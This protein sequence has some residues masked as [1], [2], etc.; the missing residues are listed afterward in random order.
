MH[1]ILVICEEAG[2]R[3]ACRRELSGE[4]YDVHWVS[5][6][7]SALKYIE[8]HKVDLVILHSDAV[9]NDCFTILEVLRSFCPDVSIILTSGRFDYWNNFMTWLADACLVPS[10]GLKEL[11]HKVS[12]LLT[13]GP[14]ADRIATGSSFAVDW[15]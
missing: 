4:G 6:G 2:L 12:E 10:P 1:K 7:H 14:A 9:D 8:Q 11:K 13:V 15:E 3:D 5:S